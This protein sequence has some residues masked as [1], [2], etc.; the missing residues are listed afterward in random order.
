M[1]FPFNII[2][3]IYCHKRITIAK[4]I[5]K[6]TEVLL[7]VKIFVASHFKSGFVKIIH[8]K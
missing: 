6:A 2:R 8:K 7:N 3:I 4:K 1:Q 5:N